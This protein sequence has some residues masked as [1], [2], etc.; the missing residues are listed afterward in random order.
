MI[1]NLQE[2]VEVEQETG[3]MGGQNMIIILNPNGTIN[4]ELMLAHGIN[5]EAIKAVTEAH[6][7]VAD[8]NDNAAPIKSLQHPIP[9]KELIDVKPLLTSSSIPRTIMDNVMTTSIA[10]TEHSRSVIL[11]PKD[12]FLVLDELARDPMIEPLELPASLAQPGSTHKIIN[13]NGTNHIITSSPGRPQPRITSQFIP[14]VHKQEQFIP[15]GL[16]N[17]IT[18]LG[19]LD[20]SLPKKPDPTVLEQFVNPG[21][22]V[23]ETSVLK[24]LAKPESGNIVTKDHITGKII[25]TN[26][27]KVRRPKAR[28]E[29]GNGTP[30]I[31]R[32]TT[33]LG[34]LG[35][36]LHG[37]LM[38]E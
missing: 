32:K 14:G 29:N 11:G 19:T 16:L 5:Q 24:A 4:E 33:S 26:G 8:D 6:G 28:D 35:Q 3:E 20:L 9:Q 30:Y 23:S 27:Q 1:F 13:I 21:A 15:A 2:T 25:R 36:A 7:L 12:N 22:L 38:G 34:A 18:P 37:P 17:N 31:H 10:G